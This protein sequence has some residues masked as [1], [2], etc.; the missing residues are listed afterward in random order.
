[1]T[2]QLVHT[3][4]KLQSGTKESSAQT[5]GDRFAPRP[6]YTS[7]NR[8]QRSNRKTPKHDW[9]DEDTWAV[10]VGLKE[11]QHKIDGASPVTAKSGMKTQATGNDET[12]KL[13]R[14][15]VSKNVEH[16]LS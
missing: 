4:E 12:Q 13:I 6:V 8:P 5:T 3:P 7:P 11:K 16:A 14:E 1:M 10:D 15:E 2:V 9:R